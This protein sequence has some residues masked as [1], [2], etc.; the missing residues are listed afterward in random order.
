MVVVVVR[1]A[2]VELPTYGARMVGFHTPRLRANYTVLFTAVL[3]GF[4]IDHFLQRTTSMIALHPYRRLAHM[5][6]TLLL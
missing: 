4:T 1:E 5:D 3:D 2:E 6:G